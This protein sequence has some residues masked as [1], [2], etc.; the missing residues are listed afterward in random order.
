[1]IGSINED[2]IKKKI[3]EILKKIQSE[4]DPG[5][6]TIYRSLIRKEISF[7]RRTYFGAYLLML[8]DQGRI[9]KRASKSRSKSG[10]DETSPRKPSRPVSFPARADVQAEPNR[11]SLPEEESIR[12]FI[13]T[14]RN[15]RVFLREILGLITA[16]TSV[17]REDIG[18]VRILDNY[19]FVQVRRTVADTIIESLNG[20]MFRGRTLTVNFAR[21]KKEEDS[22]GQGEKRD[23]A[24]EAEESQGQTARLDF[25]GSA[26]S[27]S[28]NDAG[29]KTAE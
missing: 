14:G 23:E 22:A 10:R 6:L 3:K 12:L 16:N 27:E 21:T 18:A 7:F 24:P 26:E 29:E 19:S 15:R 2:Q 25:A 5:L 9:G 8:L 4:V 1:M 11:S 17:S 20:S 13:S 28:G